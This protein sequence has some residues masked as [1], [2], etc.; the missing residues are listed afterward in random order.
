M[1]KQILT[2]IAILAVGLLAAAPVVTSVLAGQLGDQVLI[3]Y[4]LSNPFELDCEVSV[5][6]SADGGAT[7]SIFPTALSGD[8][9][10]LPAP[11]AGAD[12]EI[13]WN[14]GQDGVGPGTSYR[15]KVIADDGAGEVA[16]PVFDPPG[17]YYSGPQSVSIACA[18][19]G[20]VIRYTDDGSEPTYMSAEYTGPIEVDAT[21][22]LKAKGFKYGWTSSATASATY[23]L[24]GPMI[25]V[26]GGTFIMGDTHGGGNSNELPTHSVTLSPFYIGKYE[27]T[28]AEYAQYLQPGSSWTSNYGLGANY[29]AYN[30]SWYAILKY[31]N[32]RSIAEGFMPC[33]TISG[34]TNPADWGEVPYVY[35]DPNI[36]I[37][38]TATC[39]WSADGYRLPTEAEWEYA[40]RGAVDPPDYFYS[41]SDYINAVAW[42]DG[43]NSPHGTKPVGTKAPNE[44]G[45]HDMSGN[46]HEWCWDW[47]DSS[48]YSSSPSENPTGPASGTHRLLRGGDWLYEATNCRVSSR[49]GSFFPFVFGSLLGFRLCRAMN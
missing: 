18:T 47:Y 7:Y 15:V 6:V 33:Y 11:A 40:A 20:A 19:D 14:Y 12:Y 42:Y 43:N 22:T 39:N 26:P 44:L 38:N 4:R 8:I 34:S 5:A 32:L 21:T 16:T 3:A 25:Y 37:W 49:N 35:T 24:A 31:C 46:V 1:N 23:T 28:Q 10:L 48:Y 9:G 2:L 17:G 13:F 45:T 30:A 36:P 41:G 27:V 29:P